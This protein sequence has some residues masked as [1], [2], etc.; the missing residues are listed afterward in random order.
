MMTQF[1]KSYRAICKQ[2]AKQELYFTMSK[3]IK[4]M[5]E[6]NNLS[7]SLSI[8]LGLAHGREVRK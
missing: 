4:M 8:I 1:S 6:Q 3:N 2:N 5:E 7:P